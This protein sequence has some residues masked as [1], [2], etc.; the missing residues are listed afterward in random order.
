VSVGANAR[1][2]MISMQAKL[3]QSGHK[4]Q[5]HMGDGSMKNQFKKADKS[6][7]TLAVIIGEDESK[8]GSAS[9]K[10]LRRTLEP[11]EQQIVSQN[12]VPNTVT[13]LLESL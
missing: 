8:D 1:K 9:V 7:A 11:L 3:I 5:C 4:V 12:D 13:N 6:G 2:Q 10:V